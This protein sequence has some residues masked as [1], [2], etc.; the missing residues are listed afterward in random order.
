MPGA[1]DI[2]DKK[3][4]PD[5]TLMLSRMEKEIVRGENPDACL[6]QLSREDIWKQLGTEGQL[7]WARFAQMAGDK[8]TATAVLAHINRTQPEC[9]RAWVERLELLSVLGL[10]EEAAQ[11][12]AVARGVVQGEQYETLRRLF[13]DTGR[14]EKDDDVSAAASP[15]E[16]YRSREDAVGKYLELFSGREDCFARQWANKAEGKQGYTPVRRPLQS[17]DV[18]EH[19]SGRKTYGIYLLDSQ[20]CVKTAVIDVDLSK[21]FRKTKLKAEDRSLVKRECVYLLKRIRELSADV[22]LR[23]LVEFSGGKGYHFWYFFSAPVEATK[24]R[25]LLEPV[26]KILIGDVSAFHLEVF[27]KQDRL[28]G[29]GLGNLVKLPL[30]IHR[31]T[32][33]RSYFI[34]CHDRSLK[35][36]LDFLSKA[37]IARIE[38]LTPPRN[39]NSKEKVL[40]HPRMKKWGKEYPD[41]ACLETHCPPIGQIVAACRQAK[42][43]SM[44]EEKVLFQTIGFLPEAKRLLHYLMA[45]LPDY[46]PHLVDFKLSRLRGRPLGCKRIHSLLNFQGEQC[47]FGHK[48]EYAHPLLHIGPWE[49]D[50]RTKAEKVENL[51]SALENLK[52]AISL[53]E[54]FV[55]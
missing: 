41:L 31:L 25:T 46:N 24:A 30:G 6:R 38:D 42:D 19:L 36:Q 43:I 27:P 39:A 20:S 10:K 26:T 29:K 15:F 49:E 44:R 35:S 50:T 3:P 11:V 28:S 54:R 51:S 55:R 4:S 45:F 2:K 12:L 33:K 22:G 34:K 13:L 7:K 23:P 5:Y 37:G 40:V 52:S 16:E 18:E 53:V 47:P 17:A 9:A 1:L 8:E 32:G 14:F 48:G 21:E